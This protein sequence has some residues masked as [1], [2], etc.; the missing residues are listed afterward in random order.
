[1]ETIVIG[2]ADE[3]PA[4]SRK[5]EWADEREFLERTLTE[6]GL[7]RIRREIGG[8]E[9]ISAGGSARRFREDGT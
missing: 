3:P 1:M 2:R 7:V 9:V 8:R 5:D 4:V 6:G